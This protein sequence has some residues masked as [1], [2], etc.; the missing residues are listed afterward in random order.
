MC[1]KTDTESR[2]D[3]LLASL[4]YGSRSQVKALIQQG[5]I[6]VNGYVIRAVDCHVEKGS[7]V[8]IDQK[9]IDARLIK[10]IMLNKP[11]GVLTA[12]F[13]KKQKTVFDLLPKSFSACGCMPVGRLDKDTEGLLILSTDGELAHRILS[14]K[15]IIW[16]CYLA[17]VNGP[18]SCEDK[19]AFES[20]IR[21]SDMISLPARLEII[22]T[23]PL[24]SSAYVWVHEGKFHQVRRMFSARGL[25]V[26]SLKRLSIGP[27]K[28][29]PVLKPGEYR[30]LSE[31]E[32][33]ML[34]ISTGTEESQDE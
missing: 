32:L 18:L 34:Y 25:T 5:H 33:K 20:G 24:S 3:K 14:P 4:G 29:D 15:R 31:Q 12:A 19:E 2:L 1:M 10:H 27:L 11:V 26:T 9:Q 30:E 6:T 8:C 22:E 17:Y 7:S 21:L 13:D 16:K 23:S 28:L